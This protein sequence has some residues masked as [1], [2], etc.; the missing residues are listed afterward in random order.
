MKMNNELVERTLNHDVRLLSVSRML[1]RARKLERIPA[2]TRRAAIRG[3]LMELV[4]ETNLTLIETKI[5]WLGLAWSARGLVSLQL[6]RPSRAVAIRDL[7]REYPRGVWQDRAPAEMLRELKE[8]T[9]GRRRAFALPL[10]WS[11]IKPFQRA[12]LKAAS[13]I[14]FGETR[15][16][17]WIAHKI[18][19]PLASR[20]VGQALG[21]NPIPIILPCHRVI[22][23]DGKLGGYGGGLPMKVKLLKL[24]GAAL[25]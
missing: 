21:A 16:Y 12:V 7:Q 1:A 23:S 18:G 14:P 19:N 8:Y 2:S 4:P 15:S 10:D 13:T 25:A 9:E 11:S 5:G 17:G 6:P 24:E 3:R 22:A 20:A